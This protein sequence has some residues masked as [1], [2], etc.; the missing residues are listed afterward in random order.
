MQHEETYE[1]PI[2]KKST[3][4]RK[5]HPKHEFYIHV[6]KSVVVQSFTIVVES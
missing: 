1:S 6:M 4:D 2:L 5:G 3:S